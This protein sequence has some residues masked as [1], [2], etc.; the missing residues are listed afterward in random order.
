MILFN[1][2]SAIDWDDVPY[3]K[4]EFPPTI[5]DDPGIYFFSRKNRNGDYEPFYVGKAKRIKTRL[6]QYVCS[7][8]KHETKIR[9]YIE[10]K[11]GRLGKSDALIG[12][13][14][15]H[16]GYVAH[17]AWVHDFRQI[18]RAERALLHYFVLMG[19]DL[20]NSH[21]QPKSS[22]EMSGSKYKELLPDILQSIS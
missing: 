22:F 18:L 1:W 2:H 10:T 3:S 4:M 11:K 21:N 15:F 20:V 7:T 12:K 17:E 16:F 6:S 9:K 8:G 14:Y 19:Y 5:K 13:R